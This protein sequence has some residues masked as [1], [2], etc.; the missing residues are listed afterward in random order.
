MEVFG[1]PTSIT[2]LEGGLDL[3]ATINFANLFGPTNSVEGLPTV[4][5]VFGLD[6]PDRSVIELV[7][8]YGRDI[9]GNLTG[10]S[11]TEDRPLGFKDPT[12]GSFLVRAV[13][14]PSLSLLS[15]SLIG[16]AAVVLRKRK[17]ASD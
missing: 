3:N 1:R 12:V 17:S 9:N 10:A 11:D 4:N 2:N 5:G 15:V 8:F 16:L 13:P 14:E 6:L 7:F